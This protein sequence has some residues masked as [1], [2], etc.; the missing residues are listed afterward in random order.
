MVDRATVPPRGIS[1]E[2]TMGVISGAL[3]RALSAS[4]VSGPDRRLSVLPE[5]ALEQGLVGG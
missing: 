1:N 2:G 4:E 5:W 3:Q